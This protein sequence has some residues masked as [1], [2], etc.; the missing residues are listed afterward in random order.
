MFGLKIWHPW[1]WL[2]DGLRPHLAVLDL[3]V[4]EAVGEEDPA[5][6]CDAVGVRAVVVLVVG[7]RPQQVQLDLGPIL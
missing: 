3:W 5:K 7:Q 6:L 4:V 1:D 2:L